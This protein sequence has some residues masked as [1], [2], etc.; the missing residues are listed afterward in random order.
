[1]VDYDRVCQLLGSEHKIRDLGFMSYQQLVEIACTEGHVYQG[2]INVWKWIRLRKALVSVLSG[3]C[4]ISDQIPG[5]AT[6]LYFLSAFI[7]DK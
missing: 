1:M 6:T 5:I 3:F 2:K 7:I 4:I